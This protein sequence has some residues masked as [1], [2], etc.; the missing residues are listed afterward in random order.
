MESRQSS[1]RIAERAANVVFVSGLSVCVLNLLYIAYYYY[2]TGTKVFSSP[3]VGWGFVSTL[4]V[5]GGLFAAGLKLSMPAKGN[6]ALSVCSIA[7]SIYAVELF[8]SIWSNLPSVQE[9]EYRQTLAASA[10]GAGVDFDLRTKAQVVRDLREEGL[11][12]AVSMFPYGLVRQG[13]DGSLQSSIR[14]RGAELLPLAGI[15]RRLTVVC[16]ESGDFLTYDSDEHGFHNPPGIWD[17]VPVDVVML[18]DSFTQGWCVPSGRDFASVIRRHYPRTINLGIE[19]DGPLTMLATMKEYGGI[20]KPKITLWCLFE[21]NDLADLQR[22]MNTPLLRRYLTDGFTQ[23]LA[24]RQIEIDRELT[25][26]M[27]TFI[28]ANSTR[29][30]L[31]EVVRLVLNVDDMPSRFVSIV[32]LSALR[33]RLGLV[34]NTERVSAPP[35]VM[36]QRAQSMAGLF[37]A[38]RRTLLEAKRFTE[39]SGGRLYVVYLPSREMYRP[40]GPG[41]NPDRA[42]MLEIVREVGLPLIDIHPVFVDHGDPL[43]LFPFRYGAHYNEEGHR[44]VAETILAGVSR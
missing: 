21:S 16:N 28:D 44:L 43:A 39:Q 36:A 38:F 33:A 25:T 18:G 30:R 3:L 41:P 2:W 29:T 1:M 10:R 27:E 5:T 26:Y 20:L 11:D 15:S 9:H 40:Q 12:P 19:G 4:A 8:L 37:D 14:S 31:R 24:T 32:K 13:E 6:A 23:G 42:G 22:E 34:A 7:A 35:E 17:E